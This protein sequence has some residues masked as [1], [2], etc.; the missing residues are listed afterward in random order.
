MNTQDSNTQQSR[1]WLAVAGGFLAWLFAG[2]QMAIM[3]VAARAASRELLSGAFSE[4]E[5]GSWFAWYTVAFLLGGALGGG[6][7]GMM[8]DR[9]GR[10][11]GLGWSVLC[12]SLFAGAGAFA[13]SQPELLVIRFLAS[14]GIGGVWPNCMSLA[15]ESYPNASRPML[16]GVLGCAS[17]VGVALM[18]AFGLMHPINA[19]SWR[20][21]MMW[22]ALPGVFGLLILALVPESARWLQSRGAAK[23][24][25]TPVPPVG[26]F[27]P[28][29][30]RSTLAGIALGTVPL[31][32]AWGA[33]KWLFPWTDS[34]SA[35]LGD[36]FKGT[37]QFLWGAGASIGSF[38]GGY[39]ARMMGRRASYA[40]ISFASFVVNWS[41]F[42]FMTP[43]SSGFLGMVFLLGVVSTAFFGWLPLFLPELFP[44]SARATGSGVCYNFGR[45][46]S[47]A[48]VLGAGAMMQ[49]FGDYSRVGM[50]V[51][52]IYAIGVV[53][54]LLAPK[55]KTSVLKD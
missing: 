26:I 38:F 9:F 54:A 53:I 7:F 27:R 10:V 2:V 19:E 33:G 45:I 11:R 35:Q 39:L 47:A 42:R 1:L 48:G 46:L 3:P 52:F 4:H 31:L 36:G 40:A 5:A 25:V 17:N 51:S 44:T 22:S 23:A 55:D 14:L 13:H 49:A 21:V 8:G 43:E 16:A 30:L 50:A 20:E 29:L 6:L 24:S 34:Y 32:G 18:G 15:A 37:A 12:Y 41:I 28:P